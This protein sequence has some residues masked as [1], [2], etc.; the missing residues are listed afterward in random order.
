MSRIAKE[1]RK[2]GVSLCVIT[3]RPSELDADI[4]SQC[5]TIFA[6]RMSNSKDQ[7]FVRSTL[8]ESAEGMMYFLPLLRTAEAIAVGEGVPVPVRI[9]FDELPREYRPLSGT[10]PF[11]HTWKI[12]TGRQR[13]RRHRGRALAP[14][15]ALT[16]LDTT[17]EGGR[18]LVSQA[19]KRSFRSS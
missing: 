10:A 14:P 3:Q 8:S 6:L 13:L 9:C 12:D 11:S 5:N 4:L 17:P 19:S 1:G 18:H 16:R 15:A 2:Y 7:A